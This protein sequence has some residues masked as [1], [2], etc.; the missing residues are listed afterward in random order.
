MDYGKLPNRSIAYID[1]MS[2]YASCI[3]A[4]HDLDVRTVPIAVVGNFEQIG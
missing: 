3:A 2:F 1:M 4:L